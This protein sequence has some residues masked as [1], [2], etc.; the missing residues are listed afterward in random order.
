MKTFRVISNSHG[1]NQKNKQNYCL[2]SSSTNINYVRRHFLCD[3]ELEAT[4]IFDRHLSDEYHKWILV[5]LRR[6]STDYLLWTQKTNEQSPTAVMRYPSAQ[7][8]YAEPTNSINIGRL[9]ERE[10][11]THTIEVFICLFWNK[12]CF[13]PPEHRCWNMLEREN[14]IESQRAC[15]ELQ[16]PQSPATI[17]VLFIDFLIGKVVNGFILDVFQ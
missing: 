10:R 3:F 15:T 2:G 13:F 7:F 17:F 11:D 14:V 9:V 5:V 8:R 4:C 1:S 12:I 16:W 6:L